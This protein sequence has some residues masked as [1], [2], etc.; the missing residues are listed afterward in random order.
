MKI[1]RK[2]IL[3]DGEPCILKLEYPEEGNITVLDMQ[4]LSMDR[5]LFTAKYEHMNL[6]V[7]FEHLHKN[8]Y[9][10]DYNEDKSVCK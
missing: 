8:E 7:V 2:T 6:T 1:E 10:I 9:T 5:G 3:L 4:V